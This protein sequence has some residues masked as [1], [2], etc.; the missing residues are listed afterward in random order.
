MLALVLAV[1]SIACHLATRLSRDKSL[2]YLS[3]AFAALAMVMMG[4]GL[5]YL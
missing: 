3:G 2:G 5:Y 4:V 1:C